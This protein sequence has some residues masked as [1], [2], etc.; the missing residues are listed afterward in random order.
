MGQHIQGDSTIR[1]PGELLFSHTPKPNA[2][3]KRKPPISQI[4]GALTTDCITQSTTGELC[5][6]GLPLRVAARPRATSATALATTTLATATVVLPGEGVGGALCLLLERALVGLNK[7]AGLVGESES[8]ALETAELNTLAEDDGLGD[9][10]KSSRELLV[11][12][13]LADDSRDLA[14]VELKHGA[15]GSNGESV[16]E[17]SIGEEVGAETLLLDLLGKHSLDTLGV[18]HQ[19]PDLDAVNEVSGLLP[20]TSSKGLGGLHDVIPGVLRRPGKDLAFMVLEHT[21]VGLADDPLL[22]IRRRTGLGEQ[23]DLEEHAAG[24]IDALKE[25]E[26][27]VHVEGKLALLL[28][29]LLL[30][31]DLAVTLDH[32]TL[33]KKLLL[34]ATAADLLEGVLRVVDETLAESAKADLNEGTVVENLGGDVEVG[35][36][37]LKMGG[38]HQVARLVVLIVQSQEVDLAKHGTGADDAL[39]VLE[40]VVGKDVDELASIAGLAA[41]GNFG[42]GLSRNLLPRVLLEDLDDLGGLKEDG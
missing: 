22:D 28:E 40:Q 29:A 27:D 32:D 37:L 17:R 15:E 14:R 2:I 23:R 35:D 30:R 34:T 5:T 31:G 24:K 20:L 16:V 38:E 26:V 36:S 33:S 39:A 6:T 18:R 1:R 12:D 41:G 8:Q 25:L 42:I 9:L 10:V 11:A 3:A 21:A 4:H 7:G 19:V 13:H